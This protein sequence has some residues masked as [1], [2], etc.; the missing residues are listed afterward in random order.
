MKADLTET[1]SP[2]MASQ[3]ALTQTKDLSPSHRRNAGSGL[4]RSCYLPVSKAM[5]GPELPRELM[6]KTF[7][8]GHYEAMD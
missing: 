1:A 8:E 2:F 6:R 7:P 5:H 3:G 4:M